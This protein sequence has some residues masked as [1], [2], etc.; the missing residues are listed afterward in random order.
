M[1]I[2]LLFI[3][4]RK[5]TNNTLLSYAG[6]LVAALNFT[7][8][9]LTLHALTEVSAVLLLCLLL[10]VISSNYRSAGQLT[11]IHLSLFLLNLLSLIKP[12]FI[13]L[14]AATALIIIPVFY[15]KKYLLKPKSILTLGVVFSPLFIQLAIVK[16]KHDRFAISTVGSGTIKSY[17]L[18]QAYSELTGMNRERSIEFINTLSAKE[19]RDFCIKNSRVILR[20]FVNNVKKNIDSRPIILTDPPGFGNFRMYQ[21][22][23]NYNSIMYQVHKFFLILVLISLGILIKRK[24]YSYLIP[25]AFGATVVYSIF[26]ASGVSFLQGDRLVL[27]ALPVWVFLYCLIFNYLDKVLFFTG[28]VVMFTIYQIT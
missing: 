13:F 12:Q 21:L 14:V 11:F 20:C 10:Y 2:N 16:L 23:S 17:L 7:Y 5:V 1:S 9:A 4:I 22:M 27:P 25:I 15:F 3:S 6:S 19:L 18:A 24:E 26:F 28:V 8:I